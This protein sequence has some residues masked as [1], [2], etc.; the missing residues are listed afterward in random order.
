MP[1]FKNNALPNLSALNGVFSSTTFLRCFLQKHFWHTAY[2]LP[3]YSQIALTFVFGFVN[4]TGLIHL[5]DCILFRNI[6]AVYDLVEPRQ[7]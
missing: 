5:Y 3:V 1:A 4:L 2:W 7:I 6:A